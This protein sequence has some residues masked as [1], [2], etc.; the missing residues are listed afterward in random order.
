MLGLLALAGCGNGDSGARR[1]GGVEGAACLPDSVALAGAGAITQAGERALYAAVV[2]QIRATHRDT[3]YLDPRIE[4]VGQGRTFT[5][6][7]DS[8]LVAALL[9]FGVFAGP[10]E[11]D[12]DQRCRVSW[13]GLS[14]RLSRI[15]RATGGD[16]LVVD[17]THQAVWPVADD[18]AHPPEGRW[19]RAYLGRRAGCWVVLRSEVRAVL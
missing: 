17:V 9:A 7:H 15:L 2:Q 16:S 11:P 12:T 18:S 1:A 3:L 8:Q 4:T 13:P 19:E 14:V 10:C 6:R 5:Q